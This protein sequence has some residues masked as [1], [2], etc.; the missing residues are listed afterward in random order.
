MAVARLAG[1]SEPVLARA[2]AILAGTR[3]RLYPTGRALC[4]A[5]RSRAQRKR[6]TRPVRSQARRRTGSPIPVIETLQQLD[7]NRLT[8]LDAL[9]LVVKLKAMVD[10]SK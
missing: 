2:R 4:H 10:A 7:P 3:V 9:Q 1:V 5:A 6:A 8:P